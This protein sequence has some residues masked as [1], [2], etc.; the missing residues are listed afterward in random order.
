M[1]DNHF[2]KKML[3]KCDEIDLI[4]KNAIN[5][6]TTLILKM[7]GTCRIYFDIS[8]N[9]KG[10]YQVSNLLPNN[11][12]FLINEIVFWIKTEHEAFNHKDSNIS[13]FKK[14][15]Y[16]SR[17]LINSLMATIHDHKRVPTCGGPICLWSAMIG[18]DRR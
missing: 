3:I 13:E 8:H 6:A 9:V 11:W 1:S 17:W 7:C 18:N 16:V 12:T 10:W 4:T 5:E 15:N 2:Y 14:K